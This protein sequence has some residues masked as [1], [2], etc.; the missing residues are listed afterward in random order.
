METI[1][2]QVEKKED[3]DL[4][5]KFLSKMQ[6][7]INVGTSKNKR[8][9]KFIEEMEME[10]DIKAFDEAKRKNQKFFSLKEVEKELMKEGKL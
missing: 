9:N 7:V 3:A 2:I 4:I 10:E 8:L 5:K 6:S 1:F